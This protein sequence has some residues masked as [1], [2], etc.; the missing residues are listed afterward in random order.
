MIR[1][2]PNACRAKGKKNECKLVHGQQQQ[3]VSKEKA[4][5]RQQGKKFSGRQRKKKT[6]DKSVQGSE[7]SGH[8]SPLSDPSQNGMSAS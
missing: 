2:I 5:K 1:V 4:A 3:K 7:N 8:G 6:E